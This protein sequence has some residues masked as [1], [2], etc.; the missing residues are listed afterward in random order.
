MGLWDSGGE[1]ATTFEGP[2]ISW[3][4]GYFQ[5]DERRRYERKP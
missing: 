5:Q 3:P 2:A 4:D 1:R